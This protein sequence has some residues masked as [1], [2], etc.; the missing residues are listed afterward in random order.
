MKVSK[1]LRESIPRH[2]IDVNYG[3]RYQW[4]NTI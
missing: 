4:S 1:Y 3:T 2:D